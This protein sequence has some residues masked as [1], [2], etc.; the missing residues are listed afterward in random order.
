MSE[1]LDLHTEDA[2]WAHSLVSRIRAARAAGDEEE[3][4][5]LIAYGRAEGSEALAR[6]MDQIL[7]MLDARDTATA[8]GE[9]MAPFS[10]SAAQDG[11]LVCDFCAATDPV[12]YYEVRE[13]SIQ[14]PGGAFLSG[15]R[16]YACPRCRE[17]VDA[18]D[19]KG[20]RAWIGPKQFGLGH[21]ML[22]LGF[23]NN[24]RGAAVEFE[25]GTN[26]EAGR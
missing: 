22:V 26:P 24:R 7:A 21:R 25:P 14:G 4:D 17:L 18:S 9:D 10:I 2:P 11:Q 5:R 1:R 15:D 3:A 19:W 16:F 12:V 20:L 13:F 8:R 6:L 23:K